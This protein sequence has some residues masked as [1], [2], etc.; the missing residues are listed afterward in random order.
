[1]HTQRTLLINPRSNED[2]FVVFTELAFRVMVGIH[3]KFTSFNTQVTLSDEAL[4]M[5]VLYW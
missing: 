5:G 1:M 2:F 3:D 4:V